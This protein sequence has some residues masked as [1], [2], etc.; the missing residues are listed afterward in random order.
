[1]GLCQHAVFT[2]SLAHVVEDALDQ[3]AKRWLAE[4]PDRWALLM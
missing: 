3:A 1:M 4:C 2:T